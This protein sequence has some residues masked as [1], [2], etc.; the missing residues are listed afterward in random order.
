MFSGDTTLTDSHDAVQKIAGSAIW[1]NEFLPKVARPNKLLAE[2][3]LCMLHT[4]GMCGVI[5]GQYAMYVAGVLPFHPGI[6]TIYIPRHQQHRSPD[7]SIVLQFQHTLAFSFKSLDFLLLTDY[8]TPDNIYYAVRF[9]AETVTVRFVLIN[10][11]NPCGPRSNLD[12]VHFMWNTFTYFCTNY[13]I[14]MLQLSPETTKVVYTRHHM[15]EIG[16]GDSRTYLLCSDV[17]QDPRS[18]YELQCRAPNSCS[19]TVCVKQPLSLKSAASEIVFGMCNLSKFCFDEHTTYDE[20]I[21]VER[22]LPTQQLV[23]NMDFPNTLF[24]SYAQYDNPS[25]GRFHER[26]WLAVRV[27]SS[28]EWPTYT[29]RQFR[30]DTEFVKLLSQDKY[31]WCTFCE[32]TLFVA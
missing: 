20:Y 6:I 14:V 32:K 24:T 29:Q 16:R 3:L 21:I 7:V 12:L 22:H 26:C 1:F 31:T 11:D 27:Q 13:A 9:G 19:C 5:V 28:G 15:A 17:E 25:L 2:A 30:T 18:L 4:L 23:P 8:T 10:S